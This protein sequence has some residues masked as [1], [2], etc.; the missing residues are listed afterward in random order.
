MHLHGPGSTFRFSLMLYFFWS[1]VVSIEIFL[2]P[3][4]IASGYSSTLAG[5]VMS[6]AFFFS[7]GTGPLWGLVCD[8]TGRHRLVIILA[9]VSAA[10]A[11]LAVPGVRSF[12]PAILLLAAVYS[13]TA[14]SMPAILDSWIMEHRARDSSI[15]Y[16]VARGF[17]SLGYAMMSIGLG[18]VVDRLGLAAM[19]RVYAAVAAAVVLVV[20]SIRKPRGAETAAPQGGPAP[21]DHR[22]ITGSLAPAANTS[23]RALVRAVVSS[24]EYFWFVLASLGIFT[25]L[26]AAITFLPLLVYSVGGTNTHLGFAQAVAASSEIPFMLI[27][28]WLVK[29]YRPR[30]V[31]VTAM[32]MFV[33]RVGIL[34]YVTTPTGVVLVQLLHGASFG[35]FLP[36][37]IYF[38]DVVAPKQFKT[39]F[40][41]I[42]PA[43][44]FGIGSVT[45]SS[46]AGNVVDI[47]G[48]DALYRFTPVPIVLAV[49][50]FAVMVIRRR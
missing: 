25:S 42:A 4:L 41:T 49:I 20:L 36:A 22:I 39:V 35:L 6:A 50:L 16:G 5:Y 19:F 45:G 43:I 13:A 38:I 8:R 9:M 24:K 27:A 46:I 3:F 32:A 11:M 7:I 40:Q 34:R 12:Y 2:V 37:S 1:S 10:L 23:V 18:R 17:G 21:K 33:V 14:N 48:L 30:Y 26:R 28:A 29:R 47:F 44:Y 15:N 31:L